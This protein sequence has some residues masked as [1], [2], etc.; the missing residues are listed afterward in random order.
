MKNHIIFTYR[1]SIVTLFTKFHRPG[2]RPKGNTWITRV[3][4]RRGNDRISVCDQ[5]VPINKTRDDKESGEIFRNKLTR[6]TKK[7]I[8]LCLDLIHF[9][10][11][12]TLISLDGEYYEYHGEEREEQGLAIGGYE[13]EFLADLVAFYLFE[14]AKLNFRPSIYHGIYRDYGLVVSKG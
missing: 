5:H 13:L 8:N 1:Y 12:S 9:G 11:R 4:E 10:M 7:T 14:K 2:V 6:K 3:K